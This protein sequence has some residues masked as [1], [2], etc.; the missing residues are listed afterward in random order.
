MQD[1]INTVVKNMIDDSFELTKP[2]KRG[3]VRFNGQ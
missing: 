3:G 2:K 1:A